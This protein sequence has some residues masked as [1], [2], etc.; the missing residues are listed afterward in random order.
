MF[1]E[2]DLS[3]DLFWTNKP[4]HQSALLEKILLI[5]EFLTNLA[6]TATANATSAPDDPAGTSAPAVR[7]GYGSEIEFDGVQGIPS[8][9]ARMVIVYAVIHTQLNREL[10]SEIRRY[11]YLASEDDRRLCLAPGAAARLPIRCLK[12]FTLVARASGEHRSTIRHGFRFEPRYGL[13]L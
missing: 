4:G 10:A 8:N 3:A 6:V 13:G 7:L 11:R 5:Q 12:V 2:I 1:D 9:R